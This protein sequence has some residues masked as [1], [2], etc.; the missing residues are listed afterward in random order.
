MSVM[1]LA[2]TIRELRARGYT[3]DFNLQKDF[4]EVDGEGF[5]SP[6]DTL[7]IDQIFRF[8]VMSDPDDQSVLYAIHSTS[9]GKKGI[10]VNGY[11]IYSE[12]GTNIKADHLE[13]R[14]AINSRN[15]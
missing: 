6:A 5:H 14:S 4:S 13:R 7:V 1:G 15:S 8:D 11:G 10:L 9:T 2:E 12:S 3:E